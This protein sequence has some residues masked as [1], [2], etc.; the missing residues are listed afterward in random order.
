MRNYRPLYRYSLRLH[1]RT[2]G[3]A[4]GT[5]NGA[6]TSSASIYTVCRRLLPNSSTGSLQ[7]QIQLTGTTTMILF[8]VVREIDELMSCSVY[9]E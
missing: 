1:D 5:A 6:L 3:I 9:M 2:I 7:S 8:E 4:N